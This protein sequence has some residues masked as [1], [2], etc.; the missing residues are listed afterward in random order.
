MVLQWGLFIL[1]GYGG[2]S[3]LLIRRVGD[4][5][6]RFQVAVIKRIVLSP[7]S[8]MN[9]DCAYSDYRP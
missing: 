1:V 3:D 5:D 6:L 4:N 2:D 9:R 8:Q 7:R